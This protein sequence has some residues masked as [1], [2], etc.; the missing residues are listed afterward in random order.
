MPIIE[1]YQGDILKA[2]TQTVVNTV[3]LGGICGKG[4]AL[5]FKKHDP[6]MYVHYKKCCDPSSQHP[7]KAGMLFLW[8]HSS[9]WWIL[10]FPTKVNWWQSSSVDL[11]EAG[12]K[13][14]VDTYEQRGITSISFPPLGCGCGGLD[15]HKDVLPLM[16]K[17]LHP[18]PIPI[19][20]VTY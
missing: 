12:L 16:I 3:N 11:I 2:T 14:F 20:I 8:K 19:Y 18:L 17:Y 10:N 4:L 5:E 15:Y 1:Q 7:F 9:P 6:K 13:N